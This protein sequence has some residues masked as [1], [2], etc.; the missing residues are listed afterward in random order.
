MFGFADEDDV[1]EIAQLMHEGFQASDT[2]FD[3]HEDRIFEN[4]LDLY[5]LEHDLERDGVI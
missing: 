3:D 4:E 2:Q 1:Q 5:M